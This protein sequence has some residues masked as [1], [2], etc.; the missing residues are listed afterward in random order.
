MATDAAALGSVTCPS[1]ICA[2]MLPALMEDCEDSI[3]HVSEEG[4]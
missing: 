3:E 1:R 4:Q 2:E